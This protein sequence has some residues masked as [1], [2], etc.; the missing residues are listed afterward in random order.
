MKIIKQK[1]V[2]SSQQSPEQPNNRKAS[3][4]FAIIIFLIIIGGVFGFISLLTIEPKL[5]VLVFILYWVILLCFVFCIV[6]ISDMDR[7][8][9][10]LQNKIHKLENALTTNPKVNNIEEQEK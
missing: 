2:P 9:T 1:K 10:E 4:L 5:P 7:E 6:R 3:P 8:I